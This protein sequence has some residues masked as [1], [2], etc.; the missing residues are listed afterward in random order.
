MS[1]F[2]FP[3]L[4][5]I[6]VLCTLSLTV[7][8]QPALADISDSSRSVEKSSHSIERSLHSAETLREQ[9]KYPQ[10]LLIL[11]ETLAKVAIKSKQHTLIMGLKA[12]LLILQRRYDEAFLILSE[13]QPWA[14]DNQWYFI[15]G[16]QAHY[17]ANLFLRRQN[18]EKARR[19]FDKA[20]QL[21]AQSGDTL[22]AL[23]SGINWLRMPSQ[24]RQT[25]QALLTELQQTITTVDPRTG[26]EVLLNWAALLMDY[27]PLAQNRSAHIETL[28]NTLNL[29]LQNQQHYSTATVSQAY[30]LLARV[31]QA[32]HR[33]NEAVSLFNNAIHTAQ[34][35]P[36]L[37][38]RWEWLSGQ[39]FR[40]LGNIAA[41]VA[42]LQRAVQHLE[43]IRQDIPVDYVDGRSSFRQT[44]EPLYLELTDLL[45]QQ[46]KT[47][48]DT[49]PYL[50]Q[51][52]LTMELL[53]R[54]ELEDY[55]DN[56][57]VIE[58]QQQLDLAAVSDNTAAIY[59]IM[60]EDRLEILVSFSDRI[61]QRTVPV[62][63][64]QIKENATALA[65]SL[66]T[67]APEYFSLSAYFYDWLI[68]PIQDLLQA[69]QI[70]NLI[71]LPDGA[72]RLVPLASLND[73]QR[74]LIEQYSVV[75]SPGLTLFDTTQTEKGNIRVLLAGLSN[76]GPV[77]D[78]VSER[79]FSAI[80]VATDSQ[81]QHTLSRRLA[82]P[83]ERREQA[84]EQWQSPTPQPFS[85][86]PSLRIVRK[87]PASETQNSEN[88]TLRYISKRPGLNKPGNYQNKQKQLRQRLRI[89]NKT[90]F[91]PKAQP[92]EQHKPLRIVAKYPS[93]QAMQ[94]AQRQRPSTASLSI[95]PGAEEPLNSVTEKNSEPS[96]SLLLASNTSGQLRLKKR[97]LPEDQAQLK[98]LK[99]Q[100]LERLK[101]RLKLPGVDDEI[102]HISAMYQGHALVNEQFSKV[103]FVDD[104]LSNRYDIVHIASHGV[105]GN[106]AENSFV[107]TY[108]EL[109]DMN[110]L[111]A[112]LNHPKFARAP[113]DLMTLSA[114]QTADGD[115]RAPLGIS[116]I[117][118]RAKVRSA[119]GA[120]WAVSDAA[121]VDLMTEFYENLKQP[122]TSKAEALQA[123]QIT[124]LQQEQYRH[125]FFW[126]A[127]ILIGN[128]M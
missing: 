66:R 9:G 127:F 79:L 63:A 76:P 3:A 24:D 11:D 92:D 43:A 85:P 73:G 69:N 17:L 105:F 81:L 42:S 16:D 91:A 78:D 84:Q 44:L 120:L 60:L 4:K 124:L 82:Y 101:S 48:D 72:L 10:A 109:L 32:E 107:M 20:R 98:R 102:Q 12:N 83:R 7:N 40:A 31:Y 35:F 90:A 125:P 21:A 45:L 88:L 71:Y 61:V 99:A 59:P 1:Y 47:A 2:K 57:C 126:S 112:L 122:G 106:S 116:G 50:S 64:R 37:L 87:T 104:L 80:N 94:M 52:Q 113:I 56:R 128:W 28:F 38:F 46:A 25:Q 118:L 103:Q 19:W 62:S 70:D 117:A 39:S 77:V 22:L 18:M 33:H 26:S 108:D 29:I 111:E 121:T 27:L 74:F 36:D 54:S 34:T 23:Q 8:P 55:F 5:C 30:G 89:V 96:L 119:L 114:C 53:K 14:E 75:T 115:D 123:A 95:L 97:A 67:L 6:L 86:L 100:R 65:T 13:T 68:L 93:Q 51:A 49:Q 110:Q 15:A 58:T 41:A